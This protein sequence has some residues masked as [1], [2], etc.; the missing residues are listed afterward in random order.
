MRL[1]RTGIVLGQHVRSRPPAALTVIG[2][3]P[4]RTT[5]PAE[6]RRP[7]RA[8]PL[9]QRLR[10]G[11][12][13][14]YI[15]RVPIASPDPAADEAASRTVY[16]ETYGCQMNVAD[17]ELIAGVLASRGYRSTPTPERADVIL[18]N[19]C[20]I[21]ENAE[22]KVARRVRQLISERRGSRRV[23]IGLAGCMAQHHRDR[24]LDSIPGLDFVVGP[25]GYRSLGDLL[26]VDE[27]AASVRLD[28]RETYADILPV[29][30]AGVR[31]WLTIMRGCDRFCTFCVVP[32]VRG[33]ERSLPPDVLRE[34]LE[35]IAAQ[36]FREVIL[37]GQTVNSYRHEE[38]TFADL[39]RMACDVEGLDRIRYTSPHPADFDDAT[40]E[41]MR[42][43][44]RL[45]PYI[46]LPLQSGSDTMLE[47]MQRGHTIAEYRT[48]VDRLR[49]AM[50]EL[51]LSTDIIVGYPGETESDFEKTSRML[52][53]VGFDQ[54]FLFKY[55][56]RDG[57]RSFKLEETVSEV[58]KGRRL[59]R[60]IAE[61]QTRALRIN[62]RLIGRT[63]EVLVESTPKKQPD[64]L[65]GKNA[66]F[67]T[68][69]FEPAGAQLGEIATVL[70]EAATSQTLTGR[71]IRP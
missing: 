43:C 14:R 66:Q 7:G 41:A 6:R 54:A 13:S 4:R 51:A 39:L 23:R 16:V 8:P 53:E 15:P 57:T 56:A 71:E 25:D 21:R 64:W 27:P 50:P 5:V 60:L 63:T 11:F 44:D 47:A 55:S 30:E 34:E 45:S 46:H 28:R 59:E 49:T 35:R 67:K 10:P 31:A 33:R 65:A 32:F 42:D 26:E 20:A 58:E 40:I 9:R 12:L 70:V 48:L 2:R 24:L 18:L 37:L 1:H 69:A 62:Q 61:Q 36:G 38:T 19:T 3:T 22:E 29:R 52:D 68:V 17:S